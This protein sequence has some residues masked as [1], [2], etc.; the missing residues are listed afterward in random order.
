M[1]LCESNPRGLA[2]RMRWVFSLCADVWAGASRL[3]SGRVLRRG[4]T[5]H[6][7]QFDGVLRLAI[8]QTQIVEQAGLS[9]QTISEMLAQLKQAGK[10]RRGYG[11]LWWRESACWQ[12]PRQFH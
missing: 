10:V 2:Q 5:D 9:R 8:N 7:S 3:H 4:L 12:P 6:A 11:V 1:L